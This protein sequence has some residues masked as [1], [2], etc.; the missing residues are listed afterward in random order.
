[1]HELRTGPAGSAPEAVDV[2]AGLERILASADFDPTID[3]I[4]RIQAGRLRRSLERY[5]LLTG[6][7]DP[8]RIELPR[9]HCVPL[10]RRATR[11]DAPE[12]WTSHP[13]PAADRGGWP[14]VVLSM[15]PG[16]EREGG[17]DEAAARFVDQPAVKLDRY[18]DVRVALLRTPSGPSRSKGGCFSLTGQ[19][20]EEDGHPREPDFARRGRTLIGRVLKLPD[21]Q[22]RVADGLAKAGLVLDAREHPGGST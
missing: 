20:L 6:V 19:L 4:V 7:D 16:G 2:L 18:R 22:A 12:A 17:H 21:L 14:T 5:D 11:A 8:V 13:E 9:G 3:P 10:L 15:R 1:M